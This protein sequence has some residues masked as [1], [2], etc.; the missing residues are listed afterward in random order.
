MTHHSNDDHTRPY[1]VPTHPQDGQSRGRS[2]GLGALGAL[3]LL[4][5]IV[6]AFSGNNPATLADRAGDTN[7]G[8]S[9]SRPAPAAPGGAGPGTAVPRP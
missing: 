5:L 7:T 4:G 3:I 6:W 1:S 8:I 9:T 2:W